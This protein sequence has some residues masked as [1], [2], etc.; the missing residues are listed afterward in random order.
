ME[1]VENDSHSSSYD[2]ST[3]EEWEEE[4][5]KQQ[6]VF[7]KEQ[8]S[9]FHGSLLQVDSNVY[10]I[11][12]HLLDSKP[13]SSV[14]NREAVLFVFVTAYEQYLYS[15]FNGVNIYMYVNLSSG[16]HCNSMC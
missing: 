12:V 15:L 1:D 13:T 10:V 2:E 8:V 6:A 14:G 5:R 9:Q 3:D 7:E 16:L 11:D 4:R